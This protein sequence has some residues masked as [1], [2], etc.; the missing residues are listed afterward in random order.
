MF[1]RERKVKV[2]LSDFEIRLLLKALVCWR[3][4]LLREDKPTEDL[5]DLIIKLGK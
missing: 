2:A 5:D 3:N 4:T 1:G